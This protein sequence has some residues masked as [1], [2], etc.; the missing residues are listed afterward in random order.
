M[1]L[2]PLIRAETATNG[3]KLPPVAPIVAGVAPIVAGGGAKVV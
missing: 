3:A 1:W 2:F